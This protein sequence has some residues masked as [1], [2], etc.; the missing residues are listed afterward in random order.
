MKESRNNYS[1]LISEHDALLT[2]LA[3][4]QAQISALMGENQALK[5]RL[6]TFTKPVLAPPTEAAG[7]SQ[8]PTQVCGNCQQPIPAGNL[9]MHSL[10]CER[11]NK[12][13]PVCHELVPASEFPAHRD[14]LKEDVPGLFADIDRGDVPAVVRRLDHGASLAL[15]TPDAVRNTL[16][17]SA[18]KANSLD[19]LQ[20]F[21]AKGADVNAQNAYGETPLHISLD[22]SARNP[23]L[24]SYL[25]SQGADP[26]L[27][28]AIGDSPYALAMRQADHSLML[29]FTQ[30][31]NR[32]RGSPTNKPRTASAR[33]RLKA[34]QGS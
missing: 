30:Y 7:E 17:H 1:E 22:K 26:L 29:A 19:L 31:A 20:L 5:K 34:N 27:Q 12:R 14:G 28:N 15:L 24:V 9:A 25:L 33:S 11:M 32:T 10:H 18:V 2:Q 21:V 3:E 6:G 4:A 23:D 13:C 16:L 8:E